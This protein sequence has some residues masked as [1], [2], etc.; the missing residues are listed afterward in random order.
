MESKVTAD[1]AVLN[2]V[3]GEIDNYDD[4][5]AGARTSADNE[6]NMTIKEGIKRYPKAMAWSILLS[7]AM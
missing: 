4:V 3:R 1:Q 6:K 2:D 7:T 5:V